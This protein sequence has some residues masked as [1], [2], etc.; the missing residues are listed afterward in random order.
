MQPC[1]RIQDPSCWAGELII[2]SDETRNPVP[3][4]KTISTQLYALAQILGPELEFAQFLR[5]PMSQN[6][7]STRP[8][9]IKIVPMR[10]LNGIEK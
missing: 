3:T 10:E 5:E 9:Q 1:S 2:L 7:L 4:A 6:T 8:G